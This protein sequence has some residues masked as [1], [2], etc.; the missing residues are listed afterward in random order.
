VLLASNYEK[1]AQKL[2]GLLSAY[3]SF[4]WFVSCVT[5]SFIAPRS[6][7]GSKVKA[8]LRRLKARTFESLVEGL[9]VV[10][11]E[12]S[13]DDICDWFGKCGYF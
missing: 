5:G 3:P 1:I 2:V 7:T 8:T 13:K 4:A 10:F 9:K 11:G 6:L 12:I